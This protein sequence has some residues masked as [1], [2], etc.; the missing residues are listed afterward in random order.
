MHRKGTSVGVLLRDP[1]LGGLPE[2]RGRKRDAEAR[3]VVHRD[4]APLPANGE[5]RDAA[6]DVD[7][8]AILQ[9]NLREQREIS[10][11][12]EGK[13]RE[14]SSGT[15]ARADDI[16][17]AQR[18]PVPVLEERGKE[19]IFRVSFDRRLI[20]VEASHHAS[21]RLLRRVQERVQGVESRIDALATRHDER[22][23]AD[24]EI[25]RQLHR[26]FQR[27]TDTQASINQELNKRLDQLEQHR[28]KAERETATMAESIRSLQREFRDYT[29]ENA[30]KQRE[31][32]CRLVQ[33]EF[34][35]K[36]DSDSE[37]KA[38]Q[39][40]QAFTSANEMQRMRAMCLEVENQLHAL[41]SEMTGR[42]AALEVDRQLHR[43]APRQ[44]S[45]VDDES[46][47]EDLPPSR[48]SIAP[49]P[50]EES[51]L[52]SQLAGLQIVA[53]RETIS[54][55]LP[56]IIV[57]KPR[58]RSPPRREGGAVTE[59][60]GRGSTWLALPQ[61]G[62]GKG[63]RDSPVRQQMEL[64]RQA[65]TSLSNQLFDLYVALEN[66]KKRQ[67][68]EH[69]T[70]Q[71]SMEEM[72]RAAQKQ[73]E[74]LK[75][76]IGQDVDDLR[77]KVGIQ[78]KDLLQRH[79]DLR[80]DL[81]QRDS[82]TLVQ[83]EKVEQKMHGQL[84]T[85]KHR[86]ETDIVGLR[87]SL[88][89]KIQTLTQ[90]MNATEQARMMAMQSLNKRVEDFQRR[91]SRDIQTIR[92]ELT[93]QLAELQ[94]FVT[95]QLHDCRTSAN[96]L[97]LSL[98]TGIH[99]CQEQQNTTKTNLMNHIDRLHTDL[100][101]S[102]KEGALKAERLSRY[103][104]D[105]V[106]KIDANLKQKYRK[107]EESLASLVK[108]LE[109]SNQAHQ[110]T[111][112]DILR[113]VEEKWE[114]I[115][116]RLLHMQEGHSASITL[117]R[118]HTDTMLQ[119]IN[120]AMNQVQESLHQRLD[121]Y[122]RQFDANINSLRLALL[123]GHHQLPPPSQADEQPG[124]AS[125]VFITETHVAYPDTD[126][127]LRREPPSDGQGE[128]EQE[129]VSAERSVDEHDTLWHVRG[130]IKVRE[131][132]DGQAYVTMPARPPPSEDDQDESYG[133]DDEWQQEEQQQRQQQE[134]E[135]EGD[136]D[137]RQDDE[138]ELAA[139]MVSDV[140]RLGDHGGDNAPEYDAEEF[141]DAGDLSGD[142][143]DNDDADPPPPAAD[144]EAAEGDTFP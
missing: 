90:N 91:Q 96:D 94:K 76:T 137:D 41:R 142:G 77:E 136:F 107:I 83:I 44:S 88:T 82:Q 126:P 89:M 63:R 2:R 118:R 84:E 38:A 138:R 56:S 9:A 51:T 20:R 112:N 116:K 27:H 8:I 60:D 119:S 19:D 37:W 71:Q 79:S 141:E 109:M 11:P 113:A 58:S 66:E 67:K 29:V 59:G 144:N 7:A 134:E 21:E 131:N 36:L 100:M 14:A 104:D 49:P 55:S 5:R 73:Q 129:P 15:V 45:Y 10:E 31:E 103:V 127:H 24:L 53:Q 4:A 114:D 140:L 111:H 42:V 68:G 72:K 17:E 46:L 143:L 81:A 130:S 132:R 106:S 78:R 61:E 26:S 1:E 33:D 124:D 74:G 93:Q 69:A 3:L 64:I 52:Q 85:F 47:T 25:S 54:P 120:E 102:R 18:R 40:K 35:K 87:D 62:E 115:T 23:A 48:V 133:Q 50:D 16:I 75:G 12:E 80:E 101:E 34:Q 28:I 43:D 70:L 122:T 6:D 110:E 65:Q 30:A 98:K 95:D 123:H 57:S 22:A 121:D 128:A 39:S 13:R 105:R 32:L 86:Q 99:L 139:M 92:G 135:D 108:K 97:L 125:P 117:E